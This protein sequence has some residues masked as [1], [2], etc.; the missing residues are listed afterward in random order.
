MSKQDKQHCCGAAVT[1][2]LIAAVILM[3]CKKQ[4]HE[5][6]QSEHQPKELQPEPAAENISE[7]A[8]TETNVPAASKINLYD[9]IKAART[10]QPAYTSWYHKPAPDFTLADIAGKEHKLSDYRG[11]DVL[12]IFWATWCGPCQM[13]VPAL[14]ELRRTIGEDK[15]AMLAITSDKPSVAKRFIADQGINYSK[16]DCGC[17]SSL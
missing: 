15:L 4:P 14:I 11:K 5:P 17:D 16:H 8:K 13:E 3:G 10:W 12:L 2:M 1:I 7:S 9:V 6:T